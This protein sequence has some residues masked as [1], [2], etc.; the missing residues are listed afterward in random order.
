MPELPTSRS[1]KKRR[2]RKDLQIV[3][4]PSVNRTTKN[5]Y[6]HPKIPYVGS[7]VSPSRPSTTASSAHDILST[8]IYDLFNQ[9]D[10][11]RDSL[12]K[13]YDAER[14]ARQEAHEATQRQL[15]GMQDFLQGMAQDY[16]RMKR[17]ERMGILELGLFGAS[18]V[19][20][21]G[22]RELSGEL[23]DSMVDDHVGGAG[24][25]YMEDI[26]DSQSV[27]LGL[28]ESSTTLDRRVQPSVSVETGAEGEREEAG[29]VEEE[30]E[31]LETEDDSLPIARARQRRHVSQ[32]IS[33]TIPPQHP[34]D[35]STTESDTPV[36]DIESESEPISVEALKRSLQLGTRV[37]KIQKQYTADSRSSEGIS[38]RGAQQR[39]V[40]DA[41]QFSQYS[42]PPNQEEEDDET[43]RES[44]ITTPEREAQPTEQR[45]RGISVELGYGIT[46]PRKQRPQRKTAQVGNYYDWDRYVTGGVV[47]T[48]AQ[49]KD[50]GKEP[51][52]G[53][54]TKQTRKGGRSSDSSPG[55]EI[56]ESRVVGGRGKHGKRLSVDLGES[57]GEMDAE[58]ESIGAE[59]WLE[60]RLC[61]K[62]FGNKRRFEAQEPQLSSE[63][64]AKIPTSGNAKR[65]RV[66]VLTIPGK[67]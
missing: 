66:K 29:L 14:K 27:E 43:Y 17:R 19:V 53:S 23:G 3:S 52:N 55:L 49:N 59:Y 56:V 21:S 46:S 32:T 4:P 11:F 30:E 38:R 39:G 33:P 10:E 18:G 65:R 36:D 48:P 40:T 62:N 20:S 15:A 60:S 34:H 9:L 26:D 54:P 16:V 37:K 31:E 2:L 45:L 61:G 1:A 42:V 13:A 50:K 47:S 35:G 28:D 7:S 64:P 22:K 44:P 41:N 6:D 57:S 67:A 5:N 25:V 8:Q 58:M 24:D 63:I 12:S 51:L